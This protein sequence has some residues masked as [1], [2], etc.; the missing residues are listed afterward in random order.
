MSKSKSS[1]SRPVD[2][3]W[4]KIE[5]EPVEVDADQVETSVLFVG[6]SGSGK[7]TLIN[8]FLKASSTKQPKPTFALDYSFARKKTSSSI[9]SSGGKSVAHVWELG[10]DIN[11]PGLLD[12]PISINNLNTLSV[13]VVC[14]LSRPHNVLKTIRKWIKVVREV[15]ARRFTAYEA[16]FGKKFEVDENRKAQFEGHSDK[17]MLSL[18]KIPLYVIAN[19]YDIFRDTGSVERRSTIQILRFVSHYYGATLMCASSVDSSLRDGFKN[20]INTVCFKLP[21]KQAYETNHEKPVYVYAGKDTFENILLGNKSGDSGPESSHSSGGGAK[22]RLANSEA[23]IPTFIASSGLT[24]DCWSRL[25]EHLRETYNGTPPDDDPN[26]ASKNDE[27]E[28]SEHPE[29]EIDEVRAQ[30]DVILKRYIQEAER[31]EAIQAKMNA[32]QTTSSSSMSST[33]HDDDD[34]APVGEDDS[35]H[36]RKARK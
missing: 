25:A 3:L 16:A 11:E 33:R 24:K 31:R 28:A 12:V 34:A 32:P 14:D 2:D 18:F 23:D 26:P 17:R 8:S 5:N 6:D 15:L 22:S 1:K 30:R 4:S 21:Q 35:G 27:N 7:T 36:S 19:K 29:P 10:G 20:F 13:I 9:S